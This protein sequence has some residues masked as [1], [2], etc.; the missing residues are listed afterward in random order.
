MGTN[1][2]VEK[3]SE[4]CCEHCTTKERIHLGKSSIGWKFSFYADPSWPREDALKKWMQLSASGPLVDEYGETVN[5]E[6]LLSK[7]IYK[8]GG[9]SHCVD[10]G[11]DITG[12]YFSMFKDN[13]FYCNGFDFTDREFS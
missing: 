7:I 4:G 5:R 6:D 13:H 3:T 2:Y 9:L 12:P 8:Q 1:F 11:P 10:N